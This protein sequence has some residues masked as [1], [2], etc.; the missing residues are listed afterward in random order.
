MLNACTYY[1]HNIGNFLGDVTLLL[2]FTLVEQD[3]TSFDST[4]QLILM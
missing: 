1:T 2:Y 3:N 4:K